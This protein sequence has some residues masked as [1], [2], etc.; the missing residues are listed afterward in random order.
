[1]T[2]LTSDLTRDVFLGGGLQILQPR[3]GYRAA[4]DAGRAAALHEETLLAAWVDVEL[5]RLRPGGH[6]T[7]IQ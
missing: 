5:R 7:L 4:T 3:L 2:D 6:L 1:M